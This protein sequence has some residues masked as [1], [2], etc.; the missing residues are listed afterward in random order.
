[1]LSAEAIEFIKEEIDE[2]YRDGHSDGWDE[3][4]M[5]GEA[6]IDCDEEDE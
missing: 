4:Y 2:A 1:M 3:G 6:S 5:E